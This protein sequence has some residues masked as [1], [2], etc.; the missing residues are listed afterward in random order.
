MVEHAQSAGQVQYSPNNSPKFPLVHLQPLVRI[1]FIK[2]CY[3]KLSLKQIIYGSSCRS[4]S[5]HWREVDHAQKVF[6]VT[7]TH[8][9]EK[10]TIELCIKDGHRT[11]THSGEEAGKIV[12][13]SPIRPL[14][15]LATSELAE[16]PGCVHRGALMG[17]SWKHLLLCS[18][19][20]AAVASWWSPGAA[21][22][23]PKEG[24]NFLCLSTRVVCCPWLPRYQTKE[25][26]WPVHSKPCREG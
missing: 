13:R 11:W 9:G 2:V 19:H 16:N 25:R 21:R 22:Y 5:S 14:K 15:L 6:M 10:G 24:K 17:R 20:A 4:W 23:R 1:C 7:G 18:H 3:K 12:R 8:C 26:L